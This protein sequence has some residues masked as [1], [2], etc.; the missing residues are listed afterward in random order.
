MAKLIIVTAQCMCKNGKANYIDCV[1]QT[2]GYPT[3]GSELVFIF[4]QESLSRF[5][6][7]TIKRVIFDFGNEVPEKEIRE[8]IDFVISE[9]HKINKGIIPIYLI[10]GHSENSF[11][12]TS[13]SNLKYSKSFAPASVPCRI[14]E[15]AYAM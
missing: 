5:R 7:S 10:V 3:D 11:G 12:C 4:G 15:K 14:M 1:G 13:I 2:I 6:G 8:T 9:V